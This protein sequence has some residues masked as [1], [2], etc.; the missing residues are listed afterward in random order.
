M[1]FSTISRV[2]YV[3]KS[4][5]DM[6]GWFAVLQQQSRERRQVLG[7]HWCDPSKITEDK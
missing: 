1:A 4:L 5:N 3:I 6:F 2:L 7:H